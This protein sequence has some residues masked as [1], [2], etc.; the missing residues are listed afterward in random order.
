MSMWIDA[1]HQPVE[2]IDGVTHARPC[3]CYYC[4]DC[5]NAPVWVTKYEKSQNA[6]CVEKL[7][8]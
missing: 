6:P 8:S 4:N 2:V 1:C 5:P 7:I 3:P